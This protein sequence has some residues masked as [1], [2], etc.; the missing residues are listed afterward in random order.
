MTH[1]EALRDRQKLS[2][3]SRGLTRVNPY[4]GRAR[5]PAGQQLKEPR[6]HGA[7]EKVDEGGPHVRDERAEVRQDLLLRDGPED[8]PL[9]TLGAGRERAPMTARRGTVRQNRPGREVIAR[10]EP[11]VFGAGETRPARSRPRQDRGR[12]PVLETQ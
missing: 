5:R 4:Q 11:A 1:P 9:G 3:P 7:V 12:N 10:G 8:L 2:S 6:A